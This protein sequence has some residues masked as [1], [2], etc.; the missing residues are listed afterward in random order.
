MIYHFCIN[1]LIT[2]LQTG[3]YILYRY[4]RDLS[5]MAK[6]LLLGLFICFTLHCQRNFESSHEIIW[7]PEIVNLI[8]SRRHSL[9]WLQKPWLV[10]HYFVVS[11]NANDCVIHYSK[12]ITGAIASQITGV[13]IVCSTV[14]SGANQRKHQS[15]ASLAFV[16]R[17][18]YLIW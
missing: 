1:K 5:S 9:I 3:L 13:S 16:M 17:V 15:S 18:K 12:V 6:T 11:T 4:L 14:G 7:F 2:H 8:S 10:Y